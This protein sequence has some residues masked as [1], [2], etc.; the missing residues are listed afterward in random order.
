M[1][2]FKPAVL[3]LQ[4]SE[5]STW[6]YCNFVFEM[7]VTLLRSPGSSEGVSLTWSRPPLSRTLS[8]PV[9]SDIDEPHSGRCR[10]VMDA[11]VRSWARHPSSLTPSPYQP[12]HPY[13]EWSVCPTNHH[14]L[15]APYRRAVTIKYNVPTPYDISFRTVS[16]FRYNSARLGR[17]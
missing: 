15:A 16:T 10:E 4:Q 7:V 1:T 17:R 11:L 14:N 3:I 9:Q 6:G 5:T 8:A 12:I 2:Y 13:N